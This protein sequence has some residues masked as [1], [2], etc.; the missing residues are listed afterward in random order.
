MSDPSRVHDSF[1][2]Q[3]VFT[4]TL[5]P[6]LFVS[7]TGMYPDFLHPRIFCVTNCLCPDSF[8][9]HTVLCCI[10]FCVWY[11]YLSHTVLS[12][13]L[14]CI[15]AFFLS[16]T[17]LYSRKVFVLDCILSLNSLCHIQLCT[18]DSFWLHTVKC[19][20]EF[21][22]QHCIV[23]KIFSVPDSDCMCPWLYCVL[24]C[25]MSLSVLCPQ[26]SCVPDFCVSLTV[27]CPRLFPRFVL[28][29]RLFSL[30]GQFLA[31]RIGSQRQLA[32]LSNTALLHN[33]ALHNSWLHYCIAQFCTAHKCTA[34][35][36]GALQ[37]GELHTTE[38]W[39]YCC[40]N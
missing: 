15:L 38:H 27:L 11:K 30:N 19:P 22:V 21:W 14:F 6:R 24:G 18:E 13:N 36:I 29:R 17:F 3:T 35:H 40:E 31:R 23:C 12:H 26:L 9:S 32:S 2:S 33:T 28:F 10:P 7:Q 39:Q 37:T 1:V 25:F 20:A 16:Q 4:P 5:C 8:V 34:P